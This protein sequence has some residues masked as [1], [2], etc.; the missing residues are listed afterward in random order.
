M[1]PEL[2]DEILQLRARSARFACLSYRLSDLED[3]LRFIK[4]GLLKATPASEFLCVDAMPLGFSFFES[5]A[6]GIASAYTA[7]LPYLTL[8]I[9]ESRDG[10]FF[11]GNRDIPSMR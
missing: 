6:H 10:N 3:V 4:S 2:Q 8:G 11:V 7:P 1:H 5:T 9:S